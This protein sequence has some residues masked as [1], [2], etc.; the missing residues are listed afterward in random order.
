MADAAEALEGILD[1]ADALIRHRL[2]AIGLRV[3]HLIMSV[4]PDDEIVL[5]SNVSTDVLRS[6]GDDLRNVA[7]DHDAENPDTKH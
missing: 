1:E 5:R 6:L 2:E 7:D 3:P 4:T